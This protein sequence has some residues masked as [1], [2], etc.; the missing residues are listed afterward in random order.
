MNIPCRLHDLTPAS[1]PHGSNLST[2]SRGNLTPKQKASINLAVPEYEKLLKFSHSYIHDNCTLNELVKSFNDYYQLASRKDVNT[3]S[4]QSDFLSS[5]LPELVCV[6]LSKATRAAFGA[7]HLIVTG[8]KDILIDCTFD[9][10][11]GGRLVE[12]RKRMDVGVL[13][14]VEFK[15]DGVDID[16]SVPA[17][18]I[19]V[20]TN[21]DKN[22]ISGIEASASTLKGTFPKCLYFAIGE[23]SDFD[24]SSQNYAATSIDE[25]L[26][27]RNQ[28]RSEVRRNPSS[29]NVLNTSLLED[30][31]NTVVAHLN[32]T[33]PETSSLAN[34]LKIGRLIN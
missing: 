31:Q 18:C 24:I 34:R 21:I 14:P 28:K 6:I 30:F 33:I 3:F 23:F 26:I 32:K 7:T 4:H 10:S 29:R 20:K 25:I 2:K 9:I 1:N 16:F 22:M 13:A 11:G 27:I 5:I 15:F 19:E 17:V 12:K 8:Q